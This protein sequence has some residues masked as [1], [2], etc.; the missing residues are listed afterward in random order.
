MRRL[1]VELTIIP[2]DDHVNVGGKE[3]R[4]LGWTC[5]FALANGEE[6]ESAARWSGEP[7]TS[8]VRNAILSR[9]SSVSSAMNEE[10]IGG[11]NGY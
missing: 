9:L 4:V 3:A 7:L 6:I 2:D 1:R 8:F 10:Q 11:T 5:G